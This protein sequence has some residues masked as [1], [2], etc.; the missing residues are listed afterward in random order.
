MT[1][2]DRI[3]ALATETPVHEGLAR[4]LQIQGG[5]LETILDEI[6]QTVLG[7]SLLFE[8][9]GS[10]VTL[11]VVG[12]RLVSVEAVTGLDAPKDL[13]GAT[14]SMDAGDQ[15]AQVSTLIKAFAEKAK[16]LRVTSIPKT[17]ADASDSLSMQALQSAMGLEVEDPDASPMQRFMTRIGD[18]AAA[19]LQLEDGAVA[20]T[21]GSI[22]L[23]QGLKIA[24]STQLPSFLDSR[25]ATCPSHSDPSLTLCQD[26]VEP[27]IGMAIAVHG[28]EIALVAIRA[29]GLADVCRAWQR[30]A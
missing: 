4:Q 11:L 14:L 2:A 28:P 21:Q 29:E 27:G 5:P 18:H 7:S 26:T 12:R 15:V 1:L 16:A 8:S 13:L 22:Q 10:S 23:V 3:A 19:A 9:G 6:D 17:H 24:L 25:K 20:S 30:V